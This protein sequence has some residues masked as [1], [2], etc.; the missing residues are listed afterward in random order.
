MSINQTMQEGW[1]MVSRASLNVQNLGAWSVNDYLFAYQTTYTDT[2]V[3]TGDR[4]IA[5]QNPDNR[6]AD[7]YLYKMPIDAN[8]VRLRFLV[9]DTDDDVVNARLWGWDINGAGF[10][11]VTWTTIQAGACTCNKNPHT[12][13]SLIHLAYTDGGVAA[14][15]VGDTITGATGGATAV[16]EKVILTSGTWAGGDAAGFLDLKTIS[17]TFEA[18]NLNTP[19]QDNIAAITTDVLYFRY[20]DL[21]TESVDK[22]S[23][24]AVVDGANGIAETYFDLRGRTYLFCDFDCD[25]TATAGIDAICLAKWY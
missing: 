6:P 23:A 19:T 10:D 5:A 15:A 12:G 4:Q 2:T 3:V 24:A 16:I 7:Q 18:E 13:L 14:I 9:S 20:A 8:G 21:L 11:M 22:C 25:G 17:G 1:Q